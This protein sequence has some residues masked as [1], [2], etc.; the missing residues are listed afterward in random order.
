M[1]TITK[2]QYEK[3]ATSQYIPI[4]ANTAVIDGA[5]RGTIEVIKVED[6][7]AGYDNYI[8]SGTLLTSDITVQGIPTFYGAPA[9][10]VSID[11]YYQG[12]VMKMTSGLAI[13][14]YRRIVNY[15]GTAAQKKFILDASFLITPSAGD[16]YEVYPYAFV[17]GDGEESE[18]F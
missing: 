11:D 14:E 7:G 16:T 13:G 9:T 8:A 4:I 6:P 15:E 5:T 12:C 10:A 3:F 17:W 2:S 1:Y 18:A